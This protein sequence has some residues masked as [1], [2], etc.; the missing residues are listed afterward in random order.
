MTHQG[1]HHLTD[2]PTEWPTFTYSVY[3]P[4]DVTHQGFHHL[5]DIPTEWPTFTYSVY[6]PLAVTHQ[7]F[8]H[9]ID[10]PTERLRFT[11]SVYKPLAVTHQGFHHLT[12]IP[13]PLT[14]FPVL[15][16]LPTR[17]H[18]NGSETPRFMQNCGTTSILSGT[19]NNRVEIWLTIFNHVWFKTP[20]WDQNN[21]KCCSNLAN[22][23]R[24]INAK[25]KRDQTRKDYINSFK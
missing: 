23:G 14:V 2:I 22:E 1:F 16:K 24:F 8:H 25:C 19:R 20:T 3:K 18:E 7:G 9:L 6:K 12:D 17:T 11:Y 10:I 13:E 4:L 15:S 5:T 21:L